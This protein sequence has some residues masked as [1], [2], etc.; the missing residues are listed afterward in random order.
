MKQSFEKKQN[1]KEAQLAELFI[2]VQFKKF[3]FPGF[4]KDAYQILTENQSEGVVDD[5]NMSVDLMKRN[6]LQIGM[7]FDE[8]YVYPYDVTGEYNGYY[9]FRVSTLDVAMIDDSEFKKFALLLR[10]VEM[11]KL[12]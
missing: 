3:D 4:K 1:S 11:K 10:D 7:L 2:S 12:H 8:P 9:P 5:M 6:G